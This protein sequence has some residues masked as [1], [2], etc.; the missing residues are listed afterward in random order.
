MGSR[1]GFPF[2]YAVFINEQ[3]ISMSYESQYPSG[4]KPVQSSTK[5]SLLQPYSVGHAAANLLV[6]QT[7]LSVWPSEKFTHTDGEVT[8]NVTTTTTKGIDGS[9]NNYSDNVESSV[10]IM[11]KWLS[12]DPWLKFPGLVRRGEDVQIW[13]VGDTDQYYW[14]LLGTSNHLRRKDIMLLAISNTR[15][16]ATT[17]LTA[18]NSV[19]FEFNTVDKHI[20]L[21]TPENDGEKCR[22]VVQLNYGDANFSIADTIGNSFVM[23]SIAE[24][25]QLRNASDTFLKLDKFEM[26]GEAQESIKFKTKLFDIQT[27]TFNVDS[28]TTTMQGTT[29]T[30]DYAATNLKGSTLSMSYSSVSG[31]CGGSFGISAASVDYT[32]GSLTHNGK[33]VGDSH[34][35][36]GVKGGDDNSGP[37]N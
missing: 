14:E 27:E 37:V 2:V 21:S 22:Y 9:G 31:E 35:H 30:F 16:E 19:F 1:W 23:D 25:M 7:E 20:T 5:A 15:D 12:R 26:V 18:F 6:G 13:R 11:A 24:L 33:N 3:E 10:T 4:T 17:E 34:G 8:D 28:T 36:S 32:S 29:G